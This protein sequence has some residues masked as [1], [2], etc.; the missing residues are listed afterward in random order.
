MKEPLSHSL[1]PES[2]E[3]CAFRRGYSSKA[4]ACCPTAFQKR[5]QVQPLPKSRSNQSEKPGKAA[6]PARKECLIAQQ[7]V[8]KQGAPD[9]PPDCV[10]TVAEK[11]GE[12][13]SLLDLLEEHFDIPAAPIKVGDTTRAPLHIISQELHFPLDSVHLDQSAHSPHALRV[14]SFVGLFARE[15]DF[16]VGQNLWIGGLAALDDLEA[17]ARLGAGDPEDTPQEEVVEVVEVHVGLVKDNNLA[18]LHSRTDLSGPLGIVVTGGIN[19]GKAGQEA[20]EVKPHVALGGRLAPP[21]LGPVHTFGNQL[22]S[23][24]VH[25]VD[26]PAEPVCHSPASPSTGKSWREGLKMPEH[27][28]EKL[29]RQQRTALLARVREPVA[30]RWRRAPNRRERPTVQAQRITHIVEPDGVSQLR[31]EHRHNMTPCRKCSASTGNAGLSRQIWHEMGRNEVAE[32][33]KNAEIGSR[34]AG[35]VFVFHTLPH[36]RFKTPRPS[37]PCLFLHFLW[38]GC[39]L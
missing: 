32:L 8:A 3:I 18:G 29:L 38:D 22:N 23:C 30:A 16:L 25:N 26:R 19:Q 34:W 11:I 4:P 9:L 36:G 13:E 7:Q 33:A 28:P 15:H 2:R 21:M 12:L 17:V 1:A 39:E 31:V 24:G 6:S 20:L 5:K 14:F 27:G 37:F 10:G 35:M